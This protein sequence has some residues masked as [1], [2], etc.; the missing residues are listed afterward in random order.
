MI[1]EDLSLG[2]CVGLDFVSH[3]ELYCRPFGTACPD[4]QQRPNPQRTGGRVLSF[5][6]AKELHVLDALFKPADGEPPFTPLDT[7]YNG[8]E[9]ALSSQVNFG[10]PTS[11]D[12][13]CEEIVRGA[14]AI[15]GLDQVEQ[16][17]K[18]VAHLSAKEHLIMALT[19]IIRTHF[20]DPQWTSS[21]FD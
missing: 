9:R 3:H 12:A 16:A 20:G 6:L 5:T 14:L 10:G 4:R 7:A 1:E 13:A 17:K 11:E 2:R 19:S 21:D 15:Y 18:L 8:L